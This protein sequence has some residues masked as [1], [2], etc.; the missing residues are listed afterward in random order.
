[1]ER[2]ETVGTG[3]GTGILAA[4]AEECRDETP[5][6]SPRTRVSS[7]QRRKR[8]RLR[9]LRRRILRMSLLVILALAFV[10]G[11]STTVAA[12]EAWQLARSGAEGF[13][14]GLASVDR[15]D[16]AGATSSL[17]DAAQAFDSADARL[18]RWW[19]R[20]IGRLPIAGRQL[21]ALRAMMT[22]GHE[23]AAVGARTATEVDLEGVR[24]VNGSIDTTALRRMEGP[25]EDA[26]TALRRAEEKLDRARSPFLIPVL[27]D[28][29]SDLQVHV[30][31]ALG[32]AETAALAV[33]VGSDLFGA[34]GPRRYFVA[35][36][37][38][39][40]LRASGGIIGNFGSMSAV[41]GKLRLDRLGRTAELNLAGDP[42]SRR[43]SGPPEYLARYARFTPER[44]WQNVTMSPDFPSVGGVIQSLYPQSGGEQIDG[45]LSIDPVAL[46]AF[47]Q[48]TGPVSVPGW[49]VPLTSGNVA[50]VLLVQQYQRLAQDD[51]EDFLGLTAQTVFDRL[52]ST[53]LPRP[54]ELVRILSPVVRTGHL[55]LYSQRP[56]EQRLFERIG[57][58][59]AMPA[60][61]GDFLSV[62]VQDASGNKVDSFLHRSVHYSATFDPA[63]GA[64]EGEA[65]IRLENRAPSSGLPP[66]VINGSGA[67]PT[68]PGEN[69]LY[70]SVYSP[71]ALQGAQLNSQPLLMESDRELG[72]NVYSGFVTIASRQSVTVVVRLSGRLA[73]G[74]Y[75]LD[76]VR[77]PM[78]SPDVLDVEVALGD[79][80]AGSVEGA[81]VV[82]DVARA[83]LSEREERTYHL[84]VEA[85]G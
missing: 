34:D 66:R 85:L 51:R 29:V 45:V 30:H 25:L 24:L 70:L 26:Y 39:S 62:V 68:A 78:V 35:I 83:R 49:P 17:E 3:L 73:E 2:T 22:S 6:A 33:R 42:S 61:R 12:A 32:T 31:D 48:L 41:D 47:L 15:G 21:V 23:L 46:A 71:L 43:L 52:T 44:I 64:V 54:S 9:R 67:H 76:V 27:D 81:R 79:R 14:L 82:G 56:D 19:I 5:D 74:A 58:A 57:A 38:P 11:I 75:L 53:T 1:M 69:R 59:G 77:Q 50:D 60:V 7:S 72:R 37:T 20:P 55:M 13:Q 28:L 8:A 10:A 65:T 16:R 80:A 36:Q 4:G 84:R 63:T 40:E 18:S